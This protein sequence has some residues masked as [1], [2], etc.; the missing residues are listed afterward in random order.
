MEKELNQ[1]VQ[2]HA[3]Y[4][5]GTRG[6]PPTPPAPGKLFNDR[7]FN[8]RT[9]N[10]QTFNDQAFNDQTSNDQ[11]FNDQTFNDRTFNDQTFNDRTF[12]ASVQSYIFL[13]SLIKDILKTMVCCGSGLNFNSDPDL[14]LIRIRI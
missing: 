5:R 11:T 6:E 1:A 14:T 10:D 8:D 2:L 9:F 12:N 3:A 4:S 7:T 13:N